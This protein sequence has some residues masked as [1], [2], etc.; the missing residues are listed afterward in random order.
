M[1]SDREGGV[2]GGADQK[3]DHWVVRAGG[4]MYGR[5]KVELFLLAREEG[6]SIR[7]AAN[8]AGVSA[9]AA[10]NWAQGKLPRSYTGVPARRRI[11]VEDT[12]RRGRP[13]PEDRSA[14]EP[15]GSGPLAGLTPDQIENILPGAVLADLKAVG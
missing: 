5:E 4:R 12:R 2:F 11:R 6:M 15:S 10:Q 14:C 1:Y 7:R 9:G 8:F 13:M 3:L